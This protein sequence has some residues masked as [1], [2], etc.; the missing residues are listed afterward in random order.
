MLYIYTFYAFHL[1]FWSFFHSFDWVRIGFFISPLFILRWNFFACVLCILFFF[2]SLVV[3]LLMNLF[4]F[5]LNIVRSMAQVLPHDDRALIVLHV[6]ELLFKTK[7][8]GK[9]ICKNKCQRESEKKTRTA[10]RSTANQNP[11][12][13]QR[14]G[15]FCVQCVFAWF[16][17]WY[18]NKTAV[19]YI[20]NNYMGLFFLDSGDESRL[21]LKQLLGF[22]KLWF[23]EKKTDTHTGTEKQS[24]LLCFDFILIWGERNTLK[25]R[26]FALMII[27]YGLFSRIRTV[28][29]NAFDVVFVPLCVMQVSSNVKWNSYAK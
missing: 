22:F 19:N 27:F 1:F 10:T 5:R 16:F 21:Y 15:M 24:I 11:K 28:R 23:T 3:V 6:K 2:L 17:I 20:I 13:N 8:N 29:W 9:C 4:V 18:S 12:S 7:R 14:I 26:S 25:R